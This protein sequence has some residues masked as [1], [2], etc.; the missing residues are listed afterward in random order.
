LPDTEDAVDLLTIGR[1]KHEALVRSRV[2]EHAFMLTDVHVPRLTGSAAFVSSAEW[3]EAT[4]STYGLSNLTRE[5]LE[6]AA[7][8]RWSG[9][10][11]IS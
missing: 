5:P 2:M 8:G 6:W 1:I 3:I 11:P 10:T 7:G 9:F 4:L